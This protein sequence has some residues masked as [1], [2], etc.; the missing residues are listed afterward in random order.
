MTFQTETLPEIQTHRLLSRRLMEA[1]TPA[2]E[3]KPDLEELLWPGDDVS[4]SSQF[5]ENLDEMFGVAAR[6]MNAGFEAGSYLYICLEHL[7]DIGVED[8]ESFQDVAKRILGPAQEPA[9]S[10]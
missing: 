1:V 3:L 6:T 8:V 4:P 5:E 7:R 9:G 2:P 10:F